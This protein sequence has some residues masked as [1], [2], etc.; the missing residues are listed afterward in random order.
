MMEGN[1]RETEMRSIAALGIGFAL[2]CALPGNAAA[3]VSFE[4]VLEGGWATDVSDDGAV[5]VGNLA[6]YYE[7]F[8]WTAQTG[9]VP[10]GRSSVAVLGIGGGI[11]GVS[12]DGSGISSTIL[13]ADSTYATQGRWRTGDGW[14]ETMPPVPPDGGLLD[15]SYGSAWDISR[16]GST[17][18]GFYWRPGQPDGVAHASAWTEADGLVD[19]GSSGNQSRASGANHDGSVVVGFD[20]NP[21]SGERRPAAWVGETLHILSPPDGVGEG[22]AVTADGTIAVGKQYDPVSRIHAAAMWRWNG[23]G[24]DGTEILGWLPGT[25]AMSG[26]VVANGVTSDG[27]LVVGWN[28]FA[29]DPFYTTG[30]LWTEAGGMVPVEE[31][32]ADHGIPPD[33]GFDIRSLNGVTPDGTVIIGDGQDT[34]PPYTVRSF[35]IRLEGAV[36]APVVAMADREELRAWPNPTRAGTTLAFELTSPAPATVSV[37]DATGRLVRRLVAGPSS[38]GRHELVWDGRNSEG[39][40]VAAGVYYSRLVSGSTLQVQKVVIL[41]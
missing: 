6:A 40:R 2:L 20:E 4:Y 33:P 22:Q 32:L 31:F 25:F 35:V 38:A 28:S 26:Q 12:A 10:L 29:G 7:P 23:A 41:R 27:S 1:G 16:D 8:R 5:I 11:P 18:V 14:T 34:G 9:V 21:V 13:G 39:A 19:L 17:V 36:T 15:G 24:W 3:G 37:H 30:F